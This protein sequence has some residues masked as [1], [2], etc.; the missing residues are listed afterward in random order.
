MNTLFIVSCLLLVASTVHADI[1]DVYLEK[2]KEQFQNCAKENGF[3]EQNLRN[4]F[5]Q[6]AKAGMEAASCLRECT[7][8]SM[9]M[10]K[11]S[12]LNMDMMNEFIEAVHSENPEM[13]K[14]LKNAAVSCAEKVKGMPDDCKM[15]YSF[16]ECFLDKH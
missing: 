12:K 15:A 7:L 2:T 9:N 11:D 13:V 3:T 14:N 10:L 5:N 6:D 16:V 1:I 4:V 8:K